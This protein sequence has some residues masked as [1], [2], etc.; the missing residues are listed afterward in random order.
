[1]KVLIAILSHH[2]SLERLQACLDTWVKKCYL[3]DLVILG[4]DKMPDN[5]SGIKVFKPIKNESYKDL[6]IKMKRSFE[7]CLSREWDYLIKIDDDAYLNI[8]KLSDFLNEKS[9][10][11]LYAGQGIHFPSDKH[12][13]YLSNTGDI[14]PP[15]SFKY[16]YAQGGCYIIS[17]LALQNSI[18]KMQTPSPFNA[19]DTMVGIAMHESNIKLEDRPDLFNCG[20]KG[21]GWHN[22]G[23]RKNTS[24][25]NAQL[26]KSGYISTHKLNAQEIYK[27]HDQL[28]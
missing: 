25:E 20:F 21:E 16:Y 28:R 11:L 22:M 9:S 4:D 7:Y 1:M 6:P 18:D 10:D 2:G 19:E 14:L 15:K 8:N 24:K 5:L 23:I 27:I 3:Y 26:I 17:R 13:C 12:P